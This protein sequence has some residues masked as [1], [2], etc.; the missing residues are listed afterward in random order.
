MEVWCL[1]VGVEYL[2]GVGCRVYVNG[3]MLPVAGG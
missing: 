3:G 2:W 1:Y